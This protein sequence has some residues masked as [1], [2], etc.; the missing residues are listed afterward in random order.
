MCTTCKVKL[1]E[2]LEG[3]VCFASVLNKLQMSRAELARALKVT[4]TQI[5]HYFAGQ[6]PSAATLR[7]LRK[8]VDVAEMYHTEP[9]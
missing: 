3:S 2:R 1:T 7:T 6:Q 8:L 5:G 9:N 4:P